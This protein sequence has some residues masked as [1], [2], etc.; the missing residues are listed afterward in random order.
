MVSLQNDAIRQSSILLTT[1]SIHPAGMD[2]ILANFF[3]TLSKSFSNARSTLLF[4][5]GEQKSSL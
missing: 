4:E 3:V 5:A 2:A 1:D